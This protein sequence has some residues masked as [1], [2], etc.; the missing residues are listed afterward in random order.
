MRLVK[1]A[2]ETFGWVVIGTDRKIAIPPRAWKRYGFKVGEE[3]IFIP[4]SRKSGG[5]ALTNRDLLAEL[6]TPIAEGRILGTAHFTP[7]REVRLPVSIPRGP[8]DRLLTAFGSGHA[9][10]FISRGPIYQ[11]ALQHTHLEVFEASGP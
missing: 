7:Q 10:G 8:G 3:A 5:F 2:K 4:G 9:L 6:D 11:E 1:G